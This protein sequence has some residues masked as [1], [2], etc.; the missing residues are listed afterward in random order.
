MN[1]NVK[2]EII[3]LPGENVGCIPFD[4]GL[5]NTFLNHFPQARETKVKMKWDYTKLNSFC[6]AK[7]IISKTKKAT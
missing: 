3:K 2:P 5:K 1:L 4:T 6:R 7:E